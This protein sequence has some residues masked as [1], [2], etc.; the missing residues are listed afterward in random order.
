MS[1]GLATLMRARRRMAWN[2]LCTLRHQSSL[3]IFVILFF[4]A[5]L[6]GSLF[7][8][9]L[10]GFNFLGETGL[11]D[12]RPLVVQILFAVFFLSL[13][14]MLIFSNGI[15]AYGSLFRS[16]ET[17]F[18]LSGPLRP[19][20]VFLYKLSEALL[21]SSWAFLFIALPIIVAFGVSERAPW[22]FYPGAAAFFAIFALIP[23]A[24]GGSATLLIARFLSH[25][26]RRVLILASVT[27][28]V[29]TVAW[30]LGLMH[31]MSIGVAYTGDAW[32][33]NV[34]GHLGLT[35]LPL[36][37][38]Y[39]ICSGILR[40]ANGAVMEAS[41]W[42]LMLLSTGLFAVMISVH[43][44]RWFYPAAYHQAQALGRRR[45]GRVTGRFYR[46]LDAVLPGM[47]S[48]LRALVI[49]DVKTFL[50]DPV[51]WSQVLIF[52]GLLGVY[53]ANMR[54]LRYDL[55][56]PFWKNLISLLNLIATSLTLSTFTS[57][58][59]FPLLSLEGRKFWILG[60]LPLERRNLLYSKFWFAFIGSF[61]ISE[62]LMTVSDLVLRV[63]GEVMWIHVIAMLIICSGLSALAVGIG[64]LYPNLREDN[65]SKIVSGFGGTLNLVLSVMFVA[66]IIVLLAVP[67]HVSQMDRPGLEGL[68][69]FLLP[70]GLLAVATGVVAVI[71]PMWLGV[72]AFQRLET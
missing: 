5:G 47:D 8:L 61:L 33:R 43:L 50:R 17:E 70:G 65:P 38:S 3:K 31:A 63:P 34:L 48:D 9:F 25:S 54:N 10:G 14:I 19:W 45:R 35:R 57:R 42:F 56:L 6:W 30:G 2:S 26:P 1:E 69:R 13:L 44:A 18:L 67:Y 46:A 20:K 71:V 15:I 7:W 28:A 24:V 12:F 4:A 41:F 55:N 72:R 62:G 51:Q 68:R 23:A 21:F 59:I 39:W 66:L 11:A 53:F 37:P 52:F 40:L 36:L 49:K 29:P 16:E 58:F 64:A 32:I 27:A 60:L 22:Y